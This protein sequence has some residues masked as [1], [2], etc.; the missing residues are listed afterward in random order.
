MPRSYPAG[1]ERASYH[2]R[3]DFMRTLLERDFPQWGVQ[4][5]ATALQRFWNTLAH[6]H[7]QLWNAAEL[8]RVLGVNANTA[9]RYLDLLTDALVVRQL[10]PWRANLGKRQVKS[11]KVYIRDSGLLHRLLGVTDRRALE[12]HPGLGASWEGFAIEQV[13]AT[14]PYDEA[15]FW[16]VHQG[17]EIDL[18]IS[19]GGRLYGVEMKRTDAPTVKGSL[20]LDVLGNFVLRRLD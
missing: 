20:F 16:A 17:A 15:W 10:Q 8:A 13:L 18:V 12:N 7:A 2:W 9:R 5:A 4:V 6:R 19:D 3:R 14:Q 11:P 1:S